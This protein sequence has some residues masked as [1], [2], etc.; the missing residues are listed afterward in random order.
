M[1]FTL[2]DQHPQWCETS[3]HGDAVQTSF[4]LDLAMPAHIEMWPI[5]LP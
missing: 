5:D 1:I 2:L 3:D 4:S